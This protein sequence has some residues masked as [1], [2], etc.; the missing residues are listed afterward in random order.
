MKVKLIGKT[1]IV[2]L[3]LPQRVF[4]NYWIT[5]ENKDNLINIEAVNDKW[6]IKSND[7]V[8]IIGDNSYLESL[9]LESN[10]FYYFHDL[11]SDE[12]YRCFVGETFDS[13]M[14]LLDFTENAD[15]DFFIGNSSNSE[16][17][18][19]NYISYENPSIHFNQ[20]SITRR[21]G[22]YELHNLNPDVNVYVNN[23]VNNNCYLKYGDTV[24]IEGLVFS[25]V[26]N[27]LMLGTIGNKVK[28]VTNKFVKH[29]SRRLDYGSIGNLTD[30]NIDL[31][32]KEDYFVR[33]PRFNQIIT[34]KEF[35]VDAPPKKQDTEATPL[36]LT[37]GPMLVMGMSSAVSGGIALLSVIKGESTL[38]DN[39]T[40]ILTAACMLIAMII[41]PTIT[42][43]YN[44]HKE[45]QKEEE[46][47]EKYHEYL[48]KLNKDVTDECTRQKRILIENNVDLAGVGDI[49]LYKKRNLWERKLAHED[50]LELR[51][52][53]GNV[54]PKVKIN[55]AP[56]HF[57]LKEDNLEKELREIIN[58]NKIITDVPVTLNFKE[59]YVTALIGKLPVL[60]RYTEGLILQMMA[61]HAYTDLKIVFLTAKQNKIYWDKFHNTPYCWTDEHSFRFFGNDSD[62]ITRISS[63]LEREFNSR[64][65]IPVERDAHINYG[66]HYV[67]ITD[68]I[69]AVNKT[70]I[71]QKILKSSRGLGFSI[72]YLTEKL[73]SLPSECSTFVS[74]DPNI[75]GIFENELVNSKQE[76]VPDFTVN[77]I[78][79]YIY[80]ISNIPIEK[81]AGAFELPTAYTFLEMYNAG[82]VAQ[83]NAFNRWQKND[84]TTSL[85]APVGIDTNGDLFKLDLHEKVHGPHGLVAG[86][87]G[88]GKSEFIIT[89]I[90]SMAVNFNP[91]EV[92]FVLIDYKGG[93]LAGAFENKETGVKL[94]HLAG[95][96]TNLDV[97]E[98]NRSLSSL[99]SELKRRQRMFNE[100]RDAT[101]EST[102]DI[103]KYQK[104]FREG[105]V[106]EPISHLF[107]ISDEF[108][109]L[110]AQQPDFMD[111]LISTARIGR[112]LG[113]HLIL[114]TQK[115]SGVVDDQIWSNSKFRV[116][117][118]VQDKQDSN[119]MLKSPEAAYLK[120]TG[121]FYL[122]VGFNEFFA[123]GQSAWAGAPYYESDKRKKAVDNSI[124]FVND[125][126]SPF[127]SI[128]NG[129]QN[130]RGV[131]KGEEIT[132][133]LS[134][135]VDLGNT[136][137][138]HVRQLWLDKIPANI[139]V[140]NLKAKYNYQKEDFVMNPV[141]GEYD[142]PMEQRQS[143]LTMP[144]S[145]L[146]NLII[147][148]SV[149]SGK[150][151]LVS[152]II[153]SLIS[154]YT[155]KEVCIYIIDFGSEAL[156]MYTKA[157][158]VGGYVANGEK[159]RITTLFRL[160]KS[161]MDER[162]KLFA[163][164]NGNY[165][166]YIKQSGSTVP[167]ILTFVNGF[168]SFNELYP[169][170][171]EDFITLTREGA[172]YGIYFT[173]T[174]NAANNIRMK[175]AQN[176]N[177]KISLQM[178]DDFDY[179]QIL[180]K[181]DVLP[182]KIMGRGL[183][184]REG[185]F[186][187]QSAY[188]CESDNINAFVTELITNSL[189]TTSERAER[190][191]TLPETV[192]YSFV[193][194]ELTGLTKVPVGVSK[195]DL[196][197]L[198]VDLKGQPSLLVSSSRLASLKKFVTSL[199]YEV[200]QVPNT[201]VY[202]VDAEKLIT[203][204]IKNVK[205]FSNAFEKVFTSFKKI[206]DD[207]T[208][209]YVKSDY[210]SDSLSKYGDMVFV[211]VGIN[212]I[213]TILG[214]NFD[215][216]VGSTL[217]ASKKLSKMSYIIV[218]TFDNLKKLEYDLWYKDIVNS[219]R[220][221]WIGNGLAEQSIFRLT[222]GTKAASATIPNS[223]GYNIV[224]GNPTLFKYIES[225][226]TDDSE[227][228]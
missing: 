22:L 213:K 120:E 133:I 3:T 116:C 144:Y 105:K 58:A 92:Q 147:Y 45:K 25:F 39:L 84:P 88:S 189:N 157:P 151:N 55:Y 51:L 164:Y 44:K 224:S 130:S 102:I 190:I 59:K 158:Q 204:S 141:I 121:R 205:Y 198:S 19:P 201:A 186:E 160:L 50:F 118:K 17:G 124:A 69:D 9:A 170:F 140:N 194:S 32:S 214:T 40:S 53:I 173:T 33:P 123:K 20:I 152:T 155:V 154:T 6:I 94:P 212:K 178:N 65:E 56:E 90:L 97:G 166:T 193:A 215:N 76:F 159:D 61:Y 207:L 200:A 196:N 1:Q 227:I 112:S 134:Y 68:D 226:D 83:L 225:Y 48:A 131:H 148:G 11:A 138:I 30:V 99:Q 139:F 60:R 81:N 82:N 175:V 62:E 221:I 185:I 184:K 73:N 117:L 222:V 8:K 179:R 181:T 71:I 137:N 156:R 122:Q 18:Q 37:L 79:S 21:Q 217:M 169:D 43:A 96:I 98:I 89:Y 172:K 52:G 197:I 228:L 24:F 108:A 91:D 219:T 86:M 93:G 220:G 23:N 31:Y 183:V 29:T 47:Q 110:K 85:S 211:I 95:T 107:I 36:I 113:V 14:L 54:K 209:I 63:E 142:A 146:G 78:D 149:G 127:K 150:E 12:K 163:N 168:E 199:T 216:L 187:F 103:Y 132:N 104:L 136:E 46:R 101:N 218:D 191:P 5:N 114:A 176:F 74:I 182:N 162:K 64:N 167:S 210:D 180:G 128:D 177:E 77:A 57:T 70:G 223:F 72:L 119:D 75:G 111:E 80:A 15:L 208:D 67:I 7:D 174:V 145:E 16:G 161:K 38:K 87:T 206:T 203:D 195:E 2:S 26:G 4:G 66:P 34:T 126:G 192:T 135:L 115:P 165:A 41:F 49:I 129:K 109:E 10:R 202:V 143:L 100:A 106:K 153:Y 27:T 35:P 125:I 13:Q 171:A 28:Y 42:K 188:P